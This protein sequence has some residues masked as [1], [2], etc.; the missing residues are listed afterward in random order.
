MK[1]ASFLFLLLDRPISIR[2]AGDIEC[3]PPPSD[4]VDIMCEGEHCFIGCVDL[5]QLPPFDYIKCDLSTGE[6]V[7]PY[8]TSCRPYDC[9]TIQSTALIVQC[10]PNPKVQI[11]FISGP[12]VIA[13]F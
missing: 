9:P 2:S 13:I 6:P 3:L 5:N 10:E 4:E 12:L 1:S 7:Q 8:P 11:I